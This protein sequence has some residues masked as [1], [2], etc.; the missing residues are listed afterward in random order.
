M[1]YISNMAEYARRKVASRTKQADDA[2]YESYTVD[3]VF[4]A[5]DGR[6]VQSEI[7]GTEDRKEAEEFYLLQQEGKSTE[8]YILWG[9]RG[10]MKARIIPQ[11]PDNYW[12]APVHP[13]HNDTENVEPDIYPGDWEPDR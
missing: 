5:P 11:E 4:I 7:F 9:R 1:P 2:P 6:R 12:W 13:A 8:D 3:Q 10:E